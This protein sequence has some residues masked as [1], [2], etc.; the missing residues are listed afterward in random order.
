MRRGSAYLVGFL[1]KNS[2]VE[3]SDEV[4]NLI[5]TLVAML[6]DADSLTVA[7]IIFF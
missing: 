7:V 1:F 2:K 4:P 6:T 5:T 3:L